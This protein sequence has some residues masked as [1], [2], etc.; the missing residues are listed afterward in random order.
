MDRSYSVVT[1]PFTRYG[2]VAAGGQRW[3]YTWTGGADLY[4]GAS[5]GGQVFSL[6]DTSAVRVVDDTMMLRHLEELGMLDG[7]G[8]QRPARIAAWKQHWTHAVLPRWSRMVMDDQERIW[9]QGFRA[10]LDSLERVL[11]LD[12]N[13]APVARFAL[14]S[15]WQL[16]AA[17]GKLVV[18]AKR[19]ESGGVVKVLSL[20]RSER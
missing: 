8:A 10:P 15:G 6:R 19:T 17:R 16:L 13:F 14:E 12:R 4:C 2:L 1:P 3:C 11:V 20:A 7:V 18:V 5:D 9:L